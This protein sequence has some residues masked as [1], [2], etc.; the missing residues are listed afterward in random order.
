LGADQSG[1]Q[2]WPVD[3]NRVGRR[4]CAVHAGTKS[5]SCRPRLGANACLRRNRRRRRRR[6]R[7]CH[8]PAARASGF[9][10]ASACRDPCSASR[11]ARAA[12]STLSRVRPCAAIESRRASRLSERKRGARRS[13]ACW[14]VR[15]S[16]TRRGPLPR[17]YWPGPDEDRKDASRAGANV[18]NLKRCA[19]RA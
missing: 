1:N 4:A 3:E 5:G 15:P 6:G 13:R 2:S 11:G 17:D 12:I 7:R 10:R 16:P 18:H 8:R 19:R 14:Q 9:P